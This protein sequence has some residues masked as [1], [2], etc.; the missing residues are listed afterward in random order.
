MSS[1]KTATE[2]RGHPWGD[3]LRERLLTDARLHAMCTELRHWMRNEMITAP[4]LARLVV[5][6][7]QLEAENNHTMVTI[8]ID[9]EP[10]RTR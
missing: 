2:V 4:D 10:G 3:P 1:P 9:D 5:L 8:R 7:A 6:A